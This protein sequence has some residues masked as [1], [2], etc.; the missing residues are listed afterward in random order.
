MAGIAG[1]FG[2]KSSME[3]VEQM[4][5]TIAHRGLDEKSV[6]Q[7]EQLSMAA[8]AP[9][10]SAARGTGLAR[11]DQ[12]VVAFDGEIYNE[13]MEGEADADVALTLHR[14]YGRAF[15]G[16]LQGVFACAIHD[17]DELLLARDAVGVRPM[18]WGPTAE[19]GVAFASEAKALVGVSDDVSELPPGTTWSSR[20][21]LAGYVPQYP[22]T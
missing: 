20:S 21:G 1:I 11:N 14:T 10:L 16:H 13:R 9:G 7:A 22:P 15:A 4:L 17:G 3:D 19:G 18:Y 6:H 12:A 2:P 8:G 5:Q